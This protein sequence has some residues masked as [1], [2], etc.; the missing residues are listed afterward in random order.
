MPEL[1]RRRKPKETDVLSVNIRYV[2]VSIKSGVKP[3]TFKTINQL[4]NGDQVVIRT[5]R[6]LTIGTVRNVQISKP[7]FKC[8]WVVGKI[9]M[10]EMAKEHFRTLTL[11]KIEE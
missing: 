8:N 6:G 1:R 7:S 4:K 11:L 9:K 5:S 10:N 2:E 3:Y